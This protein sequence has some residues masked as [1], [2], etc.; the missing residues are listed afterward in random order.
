M[1]IKLE[2]FD[3]NTVDISTN[4][5][6]SKAKYLKI[7]AKAINIKA[8]SIDLQT[9][10]LDM[11]FQKS[12][13]KDIAVVDFLRK[14]ASILKEQAISLLIRDPSNILQY[15]ALNLQARAFELKAFNIEFDSQKD[16][17]N[18]D[19]IAIHFDERAR[20]LEIE[21]EYLSLQAQTIEQQIL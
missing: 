8:Q 6:E 4:I 3:D 7:Q 14:Q 16:R 15:T 13:K 2:L 17:Q 20:S 5:L 1:S 19:L 11:E 9:W 21:S 10:S 12:Q 18:K